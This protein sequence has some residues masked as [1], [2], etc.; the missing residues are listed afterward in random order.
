MW[1]PLYCS[2]QLYTISDMIRFWLRR[3]SIAAVSWENWPVF[4]SNLRNLTVNSWVINMTMYFWKRM[5]KSCK[6]VLKNCNWCLTQLSALLVILL[7]PIFIGGG[8]MGSYRG[9]STGKLTI[10]IY[11]IGEVEHICHGGGSYSEPKHW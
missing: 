10:L 3:N 7:R 2:S 4:G 9:R 5:R 11:E 8:S 1:G 6:W